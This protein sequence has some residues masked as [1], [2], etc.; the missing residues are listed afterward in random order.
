MIGGFF[1]LNV[2]VF[3]YIFSLFMPWLMHLKIIEG[4]FRIDP[5]KG[6]KP[7]SQAKMS[8]RKNEDLLADARAA[9]KKRTMM[10]SNACD[11]LV[12]ALESSIKWCTCTQSKFSRIVHEGMD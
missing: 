6:K 1:A 2:A 7:K 9:V 12:L 4:L 3:S 11:I 10:T 8:T 5:S